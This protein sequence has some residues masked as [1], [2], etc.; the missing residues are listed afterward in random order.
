ME[1]INWL[2]TE[3]TMGHGNAIIAYYLESY[4]IVAK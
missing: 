2:K 1:M 3:H 4:K